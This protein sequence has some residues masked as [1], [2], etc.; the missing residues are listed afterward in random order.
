MHAAILCGAVLAVLGSVLGA[1][2]PSLP[3]TFAFTVN[4]TLAG[5]DSALF[6]GY[7]VGDQTTYKYS[8]LYACSDETNG[9]GL[10]CDSLPYTLFDTFDQATVLSFNAVSEHCSMQCLDGRACGGNGTCPISKHSG[11]PFFYLRMAS[12]QGECAGGASRYVYS[13]PALDP[14]AEQGTVQATYCF[15]DDTPVYVQ[16]ELDGQMQVQLDVLSFVPMQHVAPV[17]GVP[18]YCTCE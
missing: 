6:Q 11:N 10:N 18:K 12:A 17:F 13:G 16:Q 4:A 2:V 14:L 1:G 15:T 5:N 9:N 7:F 8:V 3:F